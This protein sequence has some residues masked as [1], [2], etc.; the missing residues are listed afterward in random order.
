[1][2][3]VFLYHFISQA[4]ICFDFIY[5]QFGR[6]NSGPLFFSKLTPLRNVPPF[7]IFT[8]RKVALCRFKFNRV[9]ECD[10][11]CFRTIMFQGL[12]CYLCILLA[13]RQIFYSDSSGREHSHGRIEQRTEDDFA[14]LCRLVQIDDKFKVFSFDDKAKLDQGV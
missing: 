7:L 5:P 4:L 13:V 14:Y 11:S 3:T 2:S 9:G 6:D 12:F 8:F 1:M 10:S